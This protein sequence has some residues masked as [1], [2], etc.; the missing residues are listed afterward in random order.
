MPNPKVGTV[1]FDDD[2]GATVRELKQG[3]ISFRVEKSGII[4]VSIGKASMGAEKLEDNFLALLAQLV[5]MK[6]STAKGTYVKG[7][8]ISSTMGP[9]IRVDTSD[10]QRNAEG[11]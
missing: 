3:K 6:P 8:A 9:G 5:R 10:A 2:V 7:I 1:V 4:H 11:R